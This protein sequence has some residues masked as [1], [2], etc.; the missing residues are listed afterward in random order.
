MDNETHIHVYNFVTR[1]LEYEMDMK[2][3]MSSVS[4]SQN[5]RFLLVNKVDGEARMLDLDT[6]EP[7]RSFKSGVKGG[8]FVIRAT[9][10]GAN[11]SFVI[12][13]SE[14]MSYPVP[15][16]APL[17]TFHLEGNV[18]IYHKE[19]GHLIEKLEGHGKA[20]CNSVSWSPNNP[21]MFATVGDDAKV[22]MYVC[23]KIFS[24]EPC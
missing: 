17:L 7:I 5:S 2:V 16:S 4:I 24:G 6:R 14:G 10:G 22:R 23:R 19:S 8:H 20:S 3:N 1:E 21:S 11:E 12:F 15:V 18:Y 9:Y 13:G